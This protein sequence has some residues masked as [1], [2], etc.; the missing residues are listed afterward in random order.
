MNLSSLYW[1]VSSQSGPRGYLKN[2]AM[3]IYILSKVTVRFLP[4]H[5]SNLNT[6]LSANQCLASVSEVRETDLSD[7]SIP[8]QERIRL[9]GGD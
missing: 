7:C 9:L 8:F 5:F 3:K 1:K 6:R 2:Q 4:H